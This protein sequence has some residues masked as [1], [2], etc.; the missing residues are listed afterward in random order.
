MAPSVKLLSAVIGV[1]QPNPPEGR[2]GLPLNQ[3]N[4][5]GITFVTGNEVFEFDSK[6]LGNAEV[7]GVY[8]AW[9]DASQLLPLNAVA[10]QSNNLKIVISSASGLSQTF[11]VPFGTQGYIVVIAPKHVSITISAFSTNAEGPLNGQA[12]VILYNFNP[13]FSGVETNGAAGTVSVTSQANASGGGTG[14]TQ[15]GQH[16]THQ[17]PPQRPG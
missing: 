5:N 3:P 6:S 13:L 7:S 15:T 8:G 10:Q 11:I 12:F 2:K 17:F 9:V 1:R 14:V 4:G 16:I